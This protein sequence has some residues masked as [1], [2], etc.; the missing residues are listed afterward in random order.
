[1]PAGLAGSVCAMEGS[2][3]R[4]IPYAQL[5]ADVDRARTRLLRAGLRGGECVGLAGENGYMWIVFDLALQS[6]G[7]IPVCFPPD[8]LEREGAEALAR[9]YELSLLLVTQSLSKVQRHPWVIEID[10]QSASEAR[11][12]R[13]SE[14]KLRRAAQGT[15]LC[16]VIFSSGTSGRLKALLL[17]RAGVDE[18]VRLLVDTWRMGPGDGVQVALPLSIFQQR[19]LCYAALRA[20]A[21]VHLCQ[22]AA[23]FH[24]F[25]RLRPTFV[26]APPAVFETMEN[27]YARAM[28][29]AAWRWRV[30][31]L[32]GVLP[33]R[34]PR[35]RLRR[36]LLPALSDA[37]GGRVRMLLTGSAPSKRST[38]ELF[39]AAGLPLY[40]A[41]GLAEAGFI[42][43]NR[44]GANRWMTVG[45]PVE[46]VEVDIAA[47]GEV[48]VGMKSRQ[49]IG[50]F[51]VAEDEANKV[52]LADGRV[53]TGDLG[54]FDRDG[55]LTL[56]G[57]K[58]NLVI[59][60]SGEKIS[61]E[62]AESA[63]A[64]VDGVVRVVIVG[65]DELPL[66]V[67]IAE[68]EPDRGGAD[69]IGVHDRLGRAIEAF[70]EGVPAGARVDRL[71]VTREPFTIENG[72]LTRNLKPDRQAIRRRFEPE[73]FGT[74]GV[75]A[76]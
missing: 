20:D 45:R 32:L 35:E 73:L 43:W 51:D 65:G 76:A 25:K 21:D 26:L 13:A 62:P 63:L 46:G 67:A 38:L 68:I 36:R 5:A 1:M 4:R 34:G 72:L 18:A 60:P 30:S 19:I 74:A 48:I 49:A 59:R 69:E 7:C 23:L 55:Y 75:M 53:A 66:L 22:P 47:D 6:V 3:V 2:T 14:G 15:D 9:R 27:R 16:T 11:A 71:L 61:V 33:L 58:K 37:F 29:S 57:R 56:V 24:S 39:D 50:Y 12:R 28:R 70:N 42:A 44:P 64:E 17:S 41:Y 52:F 10:A 40:Q 31:R 8:L 54:T